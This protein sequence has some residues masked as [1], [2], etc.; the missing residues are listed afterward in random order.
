MIV[1]ESKLLIC[2]KKDY[3]IHLLLYRMLVVWWVFPGE[4]KEIECPRIWHSPQQLIDPS[5]ASPTPARF[6]VQLTFISLHSTEKLFE[7]ARAFLNWNISSLYKIV[8]TKTYQNLLSK[9]WGKLFQIP[10]F[11]LNLSVKFWKFFSIYQDIWARTLYSNLTSFVDTQTNFS[12]RFCYQIDCMQLK[13]YLFNI[14]D[15][16]DVHQ[17][18]SISYAF[19][20]TFDG[21]FHWILVGTQN[22]IFKT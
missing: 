20:K 10:R 13:I 11:F 3:L 9:I 8:G 21:E 18:W 5:L 2:N 7:F 22:L 12:S 14:T 15:L 17:S 1:I 4:E 6:C 19:N 16:H